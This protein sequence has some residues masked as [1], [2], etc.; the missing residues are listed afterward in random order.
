MRPL[1]VENLGF[2]YDGLQVLSEI[3]FNIAEGKITTILG[4]NG[5]GK[6]TLLKLILGLLQPA[7]GTIRLFE[8]NLEEYSLKERAKLLAYVPQKHAPAFSYNVIDVVAM[9]RHPHGSLFQGTTRHDLEISES[10]LERLGI[11]HLKDRP[12]TELSGGEQQLVLIARALTQQA[13][14]L[15]MDEPVSG[16]DY[17]NQL[18]LLKQMT[19]LAQSGITCI[20]TSHYPEHALWTSDFAVFLKDGR[21]IRQGNANEVITSENLKKLYHADIRIIDAVNAKG[22]LKTCIPDF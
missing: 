13:R 4:P 21:L 8:K 20:N 18:M 6:T 19:A 9:G 7:K 22:R 17:G 15:V 5:S 11:T 14:I 10:S 2:A 1:V 3:S 16:L 12:Y